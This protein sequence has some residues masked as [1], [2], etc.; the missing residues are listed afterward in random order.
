MMYVKPMPFSTARTRNGPNA[1]APLWHTRPIGPVRPD[2]PR[3]E[4]VAQT[5]CL[6][7]ASPRQL[8]P[9]IRMPE[10]RANSPNSPCRSRRSSASR[11]ANPAEITIAD[12]APL[13]CSPGGRRARRCP[14]RRGLRQVLHVGVRFHPH[15]FVITR[16][17]GINPHP[18]FGL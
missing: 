7:F 12:P 1:V 2:A 16:V 17:H 18:V 9:L 5:S 8:G 15:D 6:T 4:E 13:R 3:E 10:A 11:S 14:P